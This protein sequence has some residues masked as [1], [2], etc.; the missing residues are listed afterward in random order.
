MTDFKFFKA[1]RVY[2]E[3]FYQF[4]KVFIVSDEYKKMKD[5]TKIAY[6]LLKA[7]LEI[8]ISKRQIDEEGN[9]YF[10]YTT[11]E[12]CRVLNCQ[13]Q[14]AIA[15]KKEL[16][17]FGLLLQK[18]MGFNKQLGKNNPNR[19][20]LAELKVSEN[21]IYL[22]EKF[23]RENRENVDK[24]EGMKIS[25]VFNNLNTDTI[26]T[27]DTEKERLQQQ[28]LLEQFAEVQENTFLSKDSL[29]F[30]AAFSDTIQEAHEM[31]GTI[32]RAKTKVEKEYNVVL[33]GE[34]YQEEIDKCL[35]RVMHKIKTDSTVKSPKGLFYKSFYN[36]FVE[37]T[38]EKKSHLNKNS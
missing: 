4:P 10:T 30:I 3:L 14:K 18:Q 11:N 22:L 35:R 23:D 33:I 7:R 27:I 26:D 24:S 37:C 34:D 29:K 19:L 31:V 21:D 13:K 38:I 1:D 20:Y 5:S 6:M 25:T 28:L 12:L 17:S 16:E 15:I 9:V 36:L 32:I 8:A 2:N